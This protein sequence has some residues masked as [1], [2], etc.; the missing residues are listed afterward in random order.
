MDATVS[1]KEYKSPIRKLAAF[2]EKS[3]D[4]WKDK[5]IGAKADVKRLKNKVHFLVE[6]KNDLKQRLKVLESEINQL[7]SQKQE[8]ESEALKKK[9]I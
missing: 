2:F 9:T 3:R 7:R 5:Y 4:R 1:Q 8:M 6:S